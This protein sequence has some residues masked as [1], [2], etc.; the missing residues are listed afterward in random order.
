MQVAPDG[1]TV[2]WLADQILT[3]LEGAANYSYPV[4][5]E[6]DV[7]RD[8]Q[9]IRK[10]SPDAYVIRNWVF[11]KDGNEVAFHAAPPHGQEFFD[12]TLFDVGTGKRLAQ[13]RLD[14][15]DYVIPDWA[16]KLLADDPLP[17]SDELS[18]WFPAGPTPANTAIK[19]S[20]K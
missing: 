4:A 12:C 8:G 7:W 5:L 6:L 11:L 18:N 13:W 17:D 2:G 9:V 16:K 15:K 20:Q 1:K 3:P 19:P 14:R 10:F